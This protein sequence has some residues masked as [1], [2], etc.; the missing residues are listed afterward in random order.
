MISFI[1]ANNVILSYAKLLGSEQIDITQ[2]INRILSQDIISNL[3]MPPFH[4]SAMDGYACKKNDIAKELNIIETIPAGHIP[5]KKIEE[6]Q[7][8]K[9]MTGAMLPEGADCVIIIEETEELPDNKIRFVGSIKKIGSQIIAD[10]TQKCKANICYKGED[11]KKN[12]IVLTKGEI[13]N[14]PHVAV[15]AMLGCVKPYVYRRP[16]IGII[17]TGNELVEPSE[18][19][20]GAQIR[21]SNSYQLLAQIERIGGIA[22]YYGIAKDVEPV[23]DQYLKKAIAE[24]DIIILSGGISMGDF[25][26]VPKVLANNSI[27]LHFDSVAI[28]PGK[29]LAFGTSEHI[30]CFGLAGNPVSTYIQFELFVKPFLYKMMGHSYCPKM[31]SVLLGAAISKKSTNKKT[32]IPAILKD[33]KAYPVEYHGSAHINA[34]CFSDC[35]ISIPINSAELLEGCVVNVRQL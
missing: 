22:T 28:Q 19:I 35:L 21:N 7:C 23:L 9:I 3:D 31:L 5:T 1:E 13:I 20:T 17:S 33:N 27:K 25:D 34:M 12:D 24:N 32:F 14:P 18:E 8:A 26:I 10:F 29:P 2:S 11:I 15:L 16:R 4:K 6:G 30:I